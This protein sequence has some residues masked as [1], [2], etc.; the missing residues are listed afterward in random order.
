MGNCFHDFEGRSPFAY[1]TGNACFSQQASRSALHK[2]SIRGQYETVKK[3][4]GD[5]EDVDQRDQ[6]SFSLHLYK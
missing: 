6:V 5:D 4:L 3:L 2:A 1:I